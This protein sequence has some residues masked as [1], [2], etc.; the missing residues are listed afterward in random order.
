M[1]KLTYAIPLL[2]ALLGSVE[3]AQADEYGCKVMLCLADP[4]GPMA[5]DECKPPIRK[6]IEGQSKHPREPFPSCQEAAPAEMKPTTRLFDACPD[7]TQTLDDGKFALLLDTPVYKQLADKS[8]FLRNGQIFNMQ[9]IELPAGMFVQTGIGE[10]ER[11]YEA[12]RNKICV[13]KPLGP[14][15]VSAGAEMQPL[16]V[17]AYEQLVTMA[18]ATSPR[19]VDIYISGKLYRSTRY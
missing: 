16:D 14:L 12:Q 3:V 13:A 9:P 18:P 17:V 5:Q 7:G 6:F 1:P 15:L 10:G 19:V 2:C 4:K 11:G 8:V